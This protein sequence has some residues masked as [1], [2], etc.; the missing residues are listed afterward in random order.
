MKSRRLFTE[1]LLVSFW[2]GWAAIFRAQVAAL[3]VVYPAAV[4][5]KF[6][7]ICARGKISGKKLIQLQSLSRWT[8]L[9]SGYRWRRA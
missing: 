9:L 6:V 7:G 3:P 5:K 1:S 2:G 8:G 4:L